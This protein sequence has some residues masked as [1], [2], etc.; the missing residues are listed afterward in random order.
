M[1]AGT[2]AF[3]P[4][5]QLTG[6][7]CGVGTDVYAMGC[8]I[9]EIFGEKQ[10]WKN[11]LPHTIILKVAGG[12]FPSIEHLPSSIREIAS[13]CLVQLGLR[14]EAKFVLKALC[15]LLV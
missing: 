10:I 4:P 13:L 9:V 1:Q 14:T 5:E 7:G 3:Q 2:P 15:Q 6:E 8:I 12:Q 11:M